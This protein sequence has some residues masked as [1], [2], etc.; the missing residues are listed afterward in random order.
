MC[1]ENFHSADIVLITKWAIQYMNANIA[2][3]YFVVLAF[4]VE[5]AE[6]AAISGGV[7]LTGF[8]K[9]GIIKNGK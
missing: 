9:I 7:F 8:K 5:N 6:I 2:N 1:Q 3:I 4:L